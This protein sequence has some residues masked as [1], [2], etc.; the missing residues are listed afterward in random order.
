MSCLLMFSDPIY[1]FHFYLASSYIY[2]V[3]LFAC[4]YAMRCNFFFF[5]KFRK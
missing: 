2:G 3:A 1:V 5:Q 4:I